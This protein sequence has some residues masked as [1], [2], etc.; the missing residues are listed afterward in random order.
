V[1]DFEYVGKGKWKNG[2]IYDPDNGK[3]YRCKAQLKGDTLK[4]RGFIGVSLLGRNSEWTRVA[5]PSA[6]AAEAE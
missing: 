2:Y 4:V 3:T 6:G 1:W 5:E